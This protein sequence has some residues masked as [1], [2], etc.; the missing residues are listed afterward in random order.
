LI[1]KSAIIFKLKTNEINIININKDS[2]KRKIKIFLNIFYEIFLD[3]DEKKTKKIL[4][5]NIF[6]K[7]VIKFLKAIIIFFLNMDILGERLN[8]K[9]NPKYLYFIN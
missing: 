1:N 4:A 6:D 5:E 7:K 2:N 8:I 3:F 9:A